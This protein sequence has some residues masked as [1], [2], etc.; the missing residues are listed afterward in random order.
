MRDSEL[1]AVKQKR[2]HQ[3][4]FSRSARWYNCTYEVRAVVGAADLTFELWF[5]GQ[6][7]SKNHAPIRITW[8]ED[9]T[10]APGGQG[11]QGEGA[12]G[13]EGG[14]GGEG[15]DPDSTE[16]G[17]RAAVADTGSASGSSPVGSVSGVSGRPSDLV[18]HSR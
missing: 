14:G 3:A 1:E 9:G 8:D 18:S 16:H 4:L 11:G 15:V 12:V 10:A 2:R 17:G 7:F 13:L 6:R 5:N